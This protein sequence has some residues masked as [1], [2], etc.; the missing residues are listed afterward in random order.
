[1]PTEL[2]KA[3]TDYIFDNL[4]EFQINRAVTDH[5]RVYIYDDAGEYLIGGKQISEFI[6]QAIKLI[7]NN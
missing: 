1:M 6:D 3:I 7:R 2:K 5:F 4:T